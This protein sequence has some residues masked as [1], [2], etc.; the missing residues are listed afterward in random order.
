MICKKQFVILYIKRK[1]VSLYIGICR[2]QR[3]KLEKINKLPAIL[4]RRQCN[5][6]LKEIKTNNVL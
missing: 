1:F 6:K 3:N 5:S 2:L 4:K